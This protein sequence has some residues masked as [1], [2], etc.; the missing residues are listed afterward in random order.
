VFD[1]KEHNNVITDENYRR[2]YQASIIILTVGTITAV[3]FL[4]VLKRPL[5]LA[6]VIIPLSLVNIGLWHVSML[7][8]WARKALIY[9]NIVVPLVVGGL[10]NVLLRGTPLALPSYMFMIT[11]VA[12][13]FLLRPQT[14]LAFFAA[15][16]ALF[17]WS[18]HQYPFHDEWLQSSYILHAVV[19]TVLAWVLSGMLFRANNKLIQEKRLFEGLYVT[20]RLTGLYNRHKLD[21]EL[22]REI[23][24]A[25]R[26]NTPLS[27]FLVDV[28]RF[29]AVNDEYG[30]LAG[31]SVLRQIAE[32]MHSSLRKTDILGRW[33]GEE[34]MVICPN[35]DVGGA[36]LVAER[37]RES[38][39]KTQFTSGKTVSLSIG[40]DHYIVGESIETVLQRVDGLLYQ[41][42]QSGGNRVVKVTSQSADSTT[43]RL[44]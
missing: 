33:G 14:T 23:V 12:G 43:G 13:V 18:L 24:R 16:Q 40:L 5:Y 9:I 3:Y 38:V 36:Q 19:F 25:D 22:S 28:D 34:F 17:L 41:A 10:W 37:V 44:I 20:D 42:K 27:L 39:C 30:H 32:V 7:G 4:L 29:K 35:T 26:Y 1:L 11:F 6:Y 2:L 31:D 21:E 8:D 15:S